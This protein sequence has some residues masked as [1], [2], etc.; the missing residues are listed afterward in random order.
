MPF[1]STL[2][3]VVNYLLWMDLLFIERLLWQL[4]CNLWVTLYRTARNVCNVSECLWEAPKQSR[5]F[6]M[7]L[8]PRWLILD[9]LTLCVSAVVSWLCMWSSWLAVK[10][11]CSHLRFTLKF[12]PFRVTNILLNLGPTN[13]A[14]TL[15]YERSFKRRINFRPSRSSNITLFCDK[16]SFG[17]SLKSP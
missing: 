5:V 7:D 10:D 9:Q 16:T 15:R 2:F 14:I 12:P 17:Q 11:Y 8:A 6:C 3:V 4:Y 1:L 13:T